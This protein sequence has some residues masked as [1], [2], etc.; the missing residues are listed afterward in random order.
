MD[1]KLKKISIFSAVLILVVI[2]AF[3][4]GYEGY[5][6]LQGIKKSHHSLKKQNSI[7]G[8]ELIEQI[9][10]FKRLTKN[11]LKLIEHIARRELGMV[12]EGEIVFVYE[13]ASVPTTPENRKTGFSPGFRYLTGDE[14]KKLLKFDLKSFDFY[15]ELSGFEEQIH[16]GG[17]NLND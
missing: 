14:F 2:S 7:E 1:Y 4:F 15:E 13:P 11:D 16:P 3:I 5:R 17:F 12:R 9:E 8:L 6:N 10:I